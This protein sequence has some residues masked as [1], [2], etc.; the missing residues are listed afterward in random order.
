MFDLRRLHNYCTCHSGKKH[1]RSPFL[2]RPLF[3][4]FGILGLVIGSS[5]V[6]AHDVPHCNCGIATSAGDQTNQRR[7][8]A[9][10]QTETGSEGEEIQDWVRGSGTFISESDTTSDIEGYDQ[11]PV[12]R[13]TVP[14][15]REHVVTEQLPEQQF[16]SDGDHF[17]ISRLAD[18]V[19]HRKLHKFI[20]KTHRNIARVRDEVRWYRGHRKQLTEQERERLKLERQVAREKRKLEMEIVREH[21]KLQPR[22]QRKDEA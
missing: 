4:F 14:A 3:L 12:H 21:R 20:K 8:E 22:F 18:T 2:F 5:N 6:S 7:K 17:R 16:G 13:S 9:N 10:T 11:E 1:L 15:G 19:L